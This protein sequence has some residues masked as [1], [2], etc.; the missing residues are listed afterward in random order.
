M[1][2][3]LCGGVKEVTGANY[4]LEHEGTKILIDCGLSQGSHFCNESNW[5][6]FFYDPKEIEAVFVTHAHID[7]TGRLPK[8]VRDG[9]HGKIYSTPPT[10]DFAEL[11]LLDSEHILSQT[12]EKLGKPLLYTEPDVQKLMGYW[13][14]VGYHHAITVGP[15]T[16]TLY[17]SA[18]ILGSSSVFVEAGGITV[19]FS[20]DLGNTPAPIIGSPETPETA[21]YCLIEST[22][23]GR[24]HHGPVSGAIEDVI[25]ETVRA[26]GTLIMPAFAME[27]TQK[28]LFE[29]NELVENGRIPKIPV[30]LDSPLAI[31]ITEVYKH[32]ENYFDQTTTEML[33]KDR[34][35]FD[36]N[37]LTKTLTTEASK[38][39]NDV[40]PPKII[41]AGSGMS[42]GGRILHHEKRYL[43]DPKSTIVFVGYQ[44]VGSLGRRILEGAKLVRIHGEEVPVR[45]RIVVLEG[46]SAH[47]DQQQLIDWL[48]P[49]R[50]SLKKVFL[51]Q[52]EEEQGQALGQRIVNE[53]AI[54]ADIPEANTEYELI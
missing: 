43:P 39:I 42:Q 2:L 38:S 37:G 14:G 12:S 26:G 10:R 51:V 52:G 13:E 4:L 50:L 1:K 31:K 18:H 19:L 32:Y 9:F 46:Y 25:E 7:H 23:G 16:I 41:I 21:D 45:C 22:Y 8:L 34:G 44:S 27:R 40:K 15:F 24:Q 47:A 6:P 5:D 49:M 3:T 33:K 28:I 30:F 35:L 53:L 36:F 20:G 54:R 11:L 17:K 29:I 48:F